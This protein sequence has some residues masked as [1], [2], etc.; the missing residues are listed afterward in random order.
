MAIL[1]QLCDVPDREPSDPTPQEIRLACWAIQKTWTPR[2]LD[3]RAGFFARQPVNIDCV[4]VDLLPPAVARSRQP[5]QRPPDY[6]G[7]APA[8]MT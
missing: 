1:S 4:P 3:R 2:E 5:F 7:D 6:Q 8:A